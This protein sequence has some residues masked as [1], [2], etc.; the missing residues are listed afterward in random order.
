MLPQS[1]QQ[2]EP[3]RSRRGADPERSKTPLSSSSAGGFSITSWHRTP[4]AF[5]SLLAVHAAILVFLFYWLPANQAFRDMRG[6]KQMNKHTSNVS[7]LLRYDARVVSLNAAD[8]AF[9]E[10]VCNTFGCA[11]P[12][13]CSA[14]G[15]L[16]IRLRL[17]CRLHAENELWRCCTSRNLL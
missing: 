7:F 17:K 1:V 15:V 9:L 14:S 8:G 4:H 16:M 6:T 5:P 2:P 3:A 13:R 10:N 11:K 12:P